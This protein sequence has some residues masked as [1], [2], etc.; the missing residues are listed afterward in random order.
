MRLGDEAQHRAEHNVCSYTFVLWLRPKFPI[1]TERVTARM[2]RYFLHLKKIGGCILYDEEGYELRDLEAARAEALEAAR[3]LLAS[4]IKAGWDL[5]TQAI[6][7]VDAE[8]R[9]LD[10]VPL[11]TVLPKSFRPR[12]A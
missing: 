10:E 2:R 11:M 12:P 3:E 8:G 6:I 7:I 9:E 1:V 5:D 4:A